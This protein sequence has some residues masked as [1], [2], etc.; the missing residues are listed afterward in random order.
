MNIVNLWLG[1]RP[2]PQVLFV[3]SGQMQS[4]YSQ[5]P[6]ITK[7]LQCKV[8][9]KLL[10]KIL[11]YISKFL[12]CKVSMVAKF[13]NLCINSKIVLFINKSRV[14][15]ARKIIYSNFHLVSMAHN[16]CFQSHL[17]AHLLQKRPGVMVHPLLTA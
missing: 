13:L 10:S 16:T 15:S 2:L 7:I 5:S 4:S 14:K 12:R 6:Y 8:C 17:C 1:T 9:A 3:L 11:Q